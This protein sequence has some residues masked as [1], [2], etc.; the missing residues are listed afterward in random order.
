[1]DVCP[2]KK[3]T[4]CIDRGVMTIRR[5]LTLS[6]LVVLV[7]FGLNLIVFFW[8]SQKRKDTVEELRRAGERQLLIST[9]R[10][11]LANVADLVRKMRQLPETPSGPGPDDIARFDARLDAIGNNIGKLHELSER[12][13]QARVESFESVFRKLSASWR[14]FYQNQGVRQPVAIAEL[15][16]HAD[17]LSQQVMQELLPQLQHNERDLVEAA[18]AKFFQVALLTAQITILIFSI[19][20]LAA[21][22]VAWHFSRYLVRGLNQLK[23][24]AALI[25]GGNYGR[26]IAADSRD[27]VGDLARG[28]NDMSDRLLSAHEQLTRANAELE[29]RHGELRAARDEAEAAN[30]A[31]SHFLANMSHELR[32]PMNAIIGYSEMLTEEAEDLGQSDFIPDLKRINSAGRHLLGLINDILDLS[33]IEAG[34]MDLY[35]ETFQVGTLV[36]DVA[37]TI[38]PLL[39]K[40]ANVLEVRCQGDVGSIRADLTKVRQSLYNLLSNACKF[41]SSGKII[42]EAKRVTTGSKGQIVFRVTDSG[43]GMTPEQIA[44]VFESFTQADASIARKYGGTGLGLTI[45]RKFCEMMGGSIAVESQASRGTTFT[46]TLPADVEE[47]AP[48]P[49]PGG[50]AEETAASG[51]TLVLVIDDD[52]AV[53]ELVRRYLGREGYRVVC[54]ADGDDGLRLARE[55]HPAVI[56]L[57]VMMPKMD[58]WSVLSALKADPAVASIP[59]IL[60]TVVDDKSLGYALGAAEYMTK[61]IDRDRLISLLQKYRRDPASTVLIVEDEE[62]TRDMLRR[63][64]V[65]DGWGVEEAANGQAALELIL[66]KRP[67]LILLDLLMPEMDGFEF[68]EALRQTPEWRSIPIVVVTAKEVTDGDR[69]R[70]NGFVKRVIQKGTGNRDELLCEVRNLVAT[71]APPRI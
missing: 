54:A 1:M 17:P 70:L 23:E 14:R 52:A 57:D 9:I 10:E 63:L 5:R 24:G 4:P 62:S 21:F 60:L 38:Q 69:L 43:I 35:I 44:R 31:K 25:G 39:E 30:R 55:L 29:R 20:A 48:E 3:A 11:D 13:V 59:V 18:S 42:L 58:G 45:T 34:K 2:A 40:N 64:L 68:V 28:F 12:S 51:A 19:S 36:Q 8:S 65:R 47:A 15:V 22:A 67:D 71:C 61:P 33:K 27:E 41:T 46:I 66:R 53:R 37:A 26:K 6:F 50:R 32:T 16:V 7:L 56:T 49:E